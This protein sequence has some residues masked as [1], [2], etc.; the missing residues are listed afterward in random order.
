LVFGFDG[1]PWSIKEV[2]VC[3]CVCVCVLW[4]GPFGLRRF[5]HIYS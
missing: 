1:D 4:V 2:C 3:V 5:K